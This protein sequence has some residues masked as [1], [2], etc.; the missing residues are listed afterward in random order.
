MG[1]K[2]VKHFW[3]VTIVVL[4]LGS[5]LWLWGSNLPIGS[6]TLH[7]TAETKISGSAVSLAIGDSLLFKTP[8]NEVGAIQFEKMTDDLGADYLA[9]FVSPTAPDKHFLP[10]NATKGHVFEKYWK[11]RAG[12]NSYH[13]IDLGG[14]YNIECG[15]IKLGWS[16]S[17]WVYFPKGFEVAILGKDRL[18]EV[19]LNTSNINWHKLTDE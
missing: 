10:E 3:K 2:N 12:L 1:D 5:A 17:T 11:T 18:Y 16:A 6:K 4:V 7:P 8:Q 14:D 13:V 9:W 15:P 19:D